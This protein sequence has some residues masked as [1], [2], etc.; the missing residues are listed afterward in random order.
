MGRDGARVPDED[1]RPGDALAGGVPARGAPW[2]GSLR[3]R[4]ATG[5][6]SATR[7]S[8]ASSSTVTCSGASGRPR[9]TWPVRG[10]TLRHR[11]RRRQH[12]GRRAREGEHSDALGGDVGWSPFITKNADAE[13]ATEVTFDRID[14]DGTIDPGRFVTGIAIDPGNANRA[15]VTYSGYDETT[16]GAEGHVFEV[17]YDSGTGTATWKRIDGGAGGLP[18]IP[19]TD[20]AHDPVLGDSYVSSD[21][22]V[23]RPRQGRSD[24]GEAAPGLPLVMVPSLTIV[25]EHRF[26]LAATHVWRLAAE[27]R[28]EVVGGLRGSATRATVW[29]P[30]ARLHRVRL[31]LPRPELVARTLAAAVVA[32]VFVLPLGF[33]VRPRGRPAFPPAE[34][35][36]LLPDP[37][38]LG[39][40]GRAFDVVDAMRYTLNSFVVAT[41]AAV[42]SVLVA[43]LAGWAMARLRPGGALARCRVRRRADG[44]LTALLVPRFTLFSWVGVTDTWITATAPVSGTSPLY[45]LLFYAWAFRRIPN[46][47]YDVCRL[48]GLTPFQDLAAGRDAARAAR[49]G[50]GRKVA[51]L[52]SWGNVLDPLVYLFDPDLFTLPLGLR[53]LATL[54]RTT[55]VMLAGAVV[56][57]A[58]V[59]VLFLLAQRWFLH[60]FRGAHWPA[61]RS[62]CRLALAVL[63]AVAACGGG[64]DSRTQVRPVFVFD[65]LE[66][67]NA[68]RKVTAAYEKE[69][70]ADVQLVEASDRGDLIARLSTST[71]A[72]S[73]PD[74]FL[75]NYRFYGQFAAKDAIEP[76]DARLDESDL[77]AADDFYPQAM[78]VFQWG[79]KQQCLPQNISSLVVY[80]NRDLFRKAGLSD[81][82]ANWTWPQFVATA[83]RLTVD[84]AGN[85]IVA[86]EPDQGGRKAAIYGLGVEPRSVRVA[87][88][89]WSNGGEPCR[90]RPAPHP[91]HAFTEPKAQTALQLFLALRSTYGVIRA[92]SRSRPRWTTR[93]AS[94]TAAWRCCS[95][96]A[97]RRRRSGRS[98]TST[99]TSRR[100]RG[101]SSPRAS[102]TP[103]RTA[104]WARRAR[105]PPGRFVEYANGTE[106]QEIVARQDLTVPSLTPSRAPDARSST[107]PR[108]RG[109][110]RSSSTVPYI[111]RVPTIS[112]WPEIEDAAEGIL[113]NGLYRAAGGRGRGAARPRHEADVRARSPRRVSGPGSKASRRPSTGCR[114]SPGSIS[115]LRTVSCSSCSGRRDAA[116][117]RCFARSPGSRRST[118]AA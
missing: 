56:A 75:M 4:A 115:R 47:L 110:R 9:G 105:T 17:V 37:F 24:W 2:T 13:P 8:A 88:F 86:G 82:A 14:T 99:G 52:V 60:E 7:A 28:P 101:T 98:R 113:E 90:R 38:G 104:S 93:R 117:R 109:A 77:I 59:V 76:I 96:R 19:A 107:R 106:G 43:S 72:G 85:P 87:P 103:T 61:R 54:D 62:R 25:P 92:M 6:S 91:V 66:E 57:T 44:A 12:L 16:P 116:N 73:P 83:R 34:S 53:S 36:Q 32:V 64:D 78:S 95:R 23:S 46:E 114:R 41:L 102:S 10:R 74:V 42:L 18:N 50:G 27:P 79:G 65:T 3:P 71:A 35:P 21:F 118:P 111:R 89:V 51:F 80:Y 11:S 48:Q 68:F 45:V 108:S 49:D 26:L 5:P 58:P 63:F 112:T 1:A 33:M 97:G 81:P 20:V 15:W 29:W 94:R 39:S 55:P 69:S 31:V 67:L 84:A 70:G 40:Y 22:G 30:S 100:C